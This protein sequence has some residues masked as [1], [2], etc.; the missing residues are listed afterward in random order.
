MI[1]ERKNVFFFKQ[2]Q[3]FLQTKNKIALNWRQSIL[4][5]RP[6]KI[7]GFIVN[8]R[9]WNG[10]EVSLLLIY[11]TL[12]ISGAKVLGSLYESGVYSRRIELNCRNNESASKRKQS[13][14]KGAACPKIIIICQRKRRKRV[15]FVP[16][17]IYKPRSKTMCVSCYYCIETDL[18]KVDYFSFSRL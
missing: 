15:D 2:N 7:P 11:L 12:S 10:F 6:Q 5:F 14:L 4:Q 3:R 1:C 13:S 17:I 9:F 16:L 18:F 8:R